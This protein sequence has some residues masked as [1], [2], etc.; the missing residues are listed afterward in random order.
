MN[1][2]GLDGGS[3]QVKEHVKAELV[4]RPIRGLFLAPAIELR[5]FSA[6]RASRRRG[7]GIR[8][9][10]GPISE[11]FTKRLNKELTE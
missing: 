6:G 3:G 11:T 10:A 5:R 8:T 7:Y 9:L 2:C 4:Q 1:A